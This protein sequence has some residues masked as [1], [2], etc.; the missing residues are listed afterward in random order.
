MVKNN[1]RDQSKP[2]QHPSPRLAETG[3][4]YAPTS[5]RLMLRPEWRL[6]PLSSCLGILDLKTA[7]SVAL[8]FAVCPCS[9]RTSTSLQ[10]AINPDIQQ[11]SRGLRSHCCCDWSRRIILT[12]QPVH[13][14]SYSSCSTG[15]G[16]QGGERG[17]MTQNAK[18]T[19]RK[20]TTETCRRTPRILSTSHIYSLPTTY[21][22]PRGLSTS[23]FSG[24]STTLTMDN[25]RP[26]L[27]LRSKS[28]KALSI[29]MFR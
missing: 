4:A 12:A 26:T 23:E 13:L 16:C 5:M 17:T 1:P 27:L 19:K 10:P 18:L 20:V 3:A 8:F 25:I 2:K 11:S 29:V 7:V 6:W 15:V 22:L 14:L 24:G 21:S 28:F 9:S